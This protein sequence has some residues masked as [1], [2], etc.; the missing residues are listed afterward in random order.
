MSEL[1]FA[2]DRQV[3]LT[4]PKENPLRS[5]PSKRCCQ[6]AINIKLTD[7]NW[8]SVRTVSIDGHQ[9]E[10]VTESGAFDFRFP[11]AEKLSEAL[12]IL[13]LQSTKRVDYL[14]DVR[15]NPSRIRI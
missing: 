4:L 1:S 15:F 8:D 12:L 2:N 5:A 3:T 6:V 11:N 10:I 14:D 13:G 7:I 9:L